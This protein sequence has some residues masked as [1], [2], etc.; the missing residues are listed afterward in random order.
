MKEF[1]KVMISLL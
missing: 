1:F